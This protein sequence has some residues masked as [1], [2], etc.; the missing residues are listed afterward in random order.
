MK[1]VMGLLIVGF[2]CISVSG[3]SGYSDQQTNVVRDTKAGFCSNNLTSIIL[4]LEEGVKKGH[5]FIISHQARDEQKDIHVKRLRNL[6]KLVLVDQQV[7]PEMLTFAVGDTSEEK[8]GKVEFWVGGTLRLV[9]YVSK[10]KSL[11]VADR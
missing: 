4:F 11:C 5:M 8:T 6:R 10:N 2:L 7:P 3:Q 1:S 9:S